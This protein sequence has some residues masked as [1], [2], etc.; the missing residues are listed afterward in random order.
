[1]LEKEQIFEIQKLRNEGK[2]N[3]FI[4]EKMKVTPVTIAR[5]V[6]RLREAGY[7]VKRFARGRKK[8]E[9]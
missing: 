5:W 4:A 1:M 3:E 7:E 8:M 6:K 2:T 9:L